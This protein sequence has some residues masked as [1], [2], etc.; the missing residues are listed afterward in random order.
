MWFGHSRA[1]DIV[2]GELTPESSCSS[3]E[4]LGTVL[5]KEGLHPTRRRFA[6]AWVRSALHERFRTDR[7]AVRSG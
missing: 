1:I 6:G 7:F 3:Y 2:L 5:T 4:W